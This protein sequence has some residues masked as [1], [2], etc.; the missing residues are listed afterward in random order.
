[1]LS[2]YADLP[3]TEAITAASRKLYLPLTFGEQSMAARIEE[4]NAHPA[5]PATPNVSHQKSPDGTKGNEPPFDLDY[6]TLQPLRR[7]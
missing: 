4:A 2:E 7:L 1:V 6:D 3:A 5:F